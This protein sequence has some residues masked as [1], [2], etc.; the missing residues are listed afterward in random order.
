MIYE[1]EEVCGQLSRANVD[2][3][4]AFTTVVLSSYDGKSSS[5]RWVVNRGWSPDQHQFTIYTD[6][7]SP[8]TKAL[9]DYPLVDVLCYDPRKRLQVRAKCSCT[10]VLA[11]KAYEAHKRRASHR[12]RD[13]STTLSPSTAAETYDF[14]D[15]MHF[16]LIEARVQYYD[17]LELGTPHHRVRYDRA[18][19]WA[20]TTLVP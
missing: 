14:T 1:F 3:R 8:K 6:S 18:S 19:D 15:H 10:I 9:A 7:R 16:A 17:V 11:G 5:A 2:R 13:Y 4:H 20:G 12:S